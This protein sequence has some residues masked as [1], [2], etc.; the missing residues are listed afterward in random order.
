[1]NPKMCKKGWYKKKKKI[2]RIVTAVSMTKEEK[3]WI[4]KKN[5][6]PTAILKEAIRDLGYKQKSD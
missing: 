5:Y 2:L 1:M 3:D 4:R 6:S